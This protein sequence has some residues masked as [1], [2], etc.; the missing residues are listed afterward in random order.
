MFLRPR[1]PLFSAT[2]AGLL[3]C[4]A[5][6]PPLRADSLPTA[7]LVNF[8]SAHVS[9]L[10]VTPDGTRLL[11]VNTAAAQLMVY[12]IL[13]AGLA[14]SRVIPVGLDPVTVRARTDTEAWVVNHVSDTVT[15]LNPRTGLVTATLKTDNE[16]A[17]V[18]FAGNPQRAFVTCMQP[19]TVLVFDA[20]NPAAAPARIPLLVEEPR[21]LAVSAD[22]SRVYAA[23]YRTGNGT[24]V[25]NGRSGPITTG[26]GTGS[27][28]IIS[29]PEGPYSG[30]NP[31]PNRGAAFFPAITAPGTPPKSSLIAR[32]TADGRWLDDN[33]G[34]WSLFISGAMAP[35]TR[36]VA[37][38]DLPDR[39]VAV[40]QTATLAVT[41]QTRLMN[42]LM[43]MAVHPLTGEVTVAG[44]DA[45]NE[46][47]FEPNLNG[48]FLRVNLARFTPGGAAVIRDL[49]PH[50]DYTAARLL[51]PEQRARSLGDPRGLA[52]LADGSAAF[53]TGMGSANVAVTAGNGERLATIP[54][55]AG[56]TGIV[57]PPGN[58]RRAY[59]LNRFDASLSVLDTAA[60]AELLRLP[61]TDPTPP[62]IREGRRLL[63]DTHRTSG[64]GHISCAS[65]HVDGRT[66]HL[67]WD[68]GNP[69]GATETTGEGKTVHP[70]KG[71][72]L[73]QT[74]QDITRHPRLHWRGDR[75]SIESFHPA[76]LGL[77]SAGDGLTADEMAKL[78]AFLDTIHF[79]PNPYRN[80]NNTLPAALKLPDG[81]TANASA[82]RTLLNSDC[83][84]CHTRSKTRSELTD[85]EVGQAFIPGQFAGF[86][87]R[88][89]YDEKNT[90]TSTGGFGYF[91]DGADP[92]YVATRGL[93]LTAAILTFEGPGFGLTGAMARRDAHPAAGKQVTVTA[94]NAAAARA[95]AGALYNILI[96]SAQLGMTATGFLD[97]APR[98]YSGTS[99][100][101]VSDSGETRTISWI[102]DR[103]VAGQTFT[104][105][106]VPRGTEKRLAT[107]RNLNGV[108]DLNE[109][110]TASWVNWATLRGVTD[111]VAGNSDGDLFPNL[112]EYALSGDLGL[113]SA[114]AAP[115]LSLSGGVPA[116]SLT[117]PR[118]VTDI[119]YT[120]EQSATLRPDSWTALTG[121]PVVSV[122]ADNTETVSW[123]DVFTRAGF[124]ARG[125]LRVKVTLP[126]GAE[127]VTPPT[128]FY[129][130]ALPRGNS[131]WTAGL[132]GRAVWAG[133]VVS[134]AAAADGAGRKA[135]TLSAAA[136]P[137]GALVRHYAELLPPASSAGA[138]LDISANNGDQITVVD[139]LGACVP[140][141]RLVIR[142]HAT[143][144]TLFPGGAGLAPLSDSV[145]VFASNGGKKLHFWNPAPAP[146][147]WIDALGS[148]ATG[149]VVPPGAGVMMQTSAARALVIGADGGVAW[150]KA[151][152]LRVP[153]TPAV[154]NWAGPLTPLGGTLPLSALGFQ[155]ALRPL[156]DSVSV[157][158]P[159][160]TLKRSGTYLWNGTG[161]I[162]GS[163]T[164]AGGLP[165][166][167]GGAQVINTGVPAV[168]VLPNLLP[169]S[170]Q[171]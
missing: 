149:T 115:G 165:V 160:G 6:P 131:A 99:A 102:L 48:V 82:G 167:A 12:E 85:N 50:L 21:A 86:Y 29:R 137:Q 135:L 13:P 156:N 71:P 98:A 166:T 30:V 1:F 158:P 77:Q 146:G 78:R 153:L 117:R 20:A 22:G 129:R 100:N 121:S 75:A 27:E 142:P 144:G 19:N 63:Y 33:G 116:F 112:L 132:T 34:D 66:D 143:L 7:G 35:L 36:R 152:P 24:V 96:G 18:V 119:T 79:P 68:L 51:P 157:Y 90:A 87:D 91:H 57:I 139:P 151:G 162:S 55:G 105:T 124:T 23:G 97:G 17:D 171:P 93:D 92:I 43:A 42:V 140:G 65:C 107:D 106:L 127:A 72:M 62:A 133:S 126:G 138:T 163:G 25:L 9:P 109:P 134:A 111:G 155:S 56:P 44:T 45:T 61:F 154:N 159:D 169:Y 76:F 40:I 39:D 114:P 161:F 170:D 2:F 58:T 101:F 136:F 150:P 8:E 49:N 52:W 80:A 32:K 64:L 5:A 60:R 41:Y 104:F 113:G 164:A 47:R 118:G 16:P 14:P 70:M 125:F 4:V 10:A 110:A 147:R 28:N 11:A 95:E 37:G 148:D 69:A 123:T 141:T 54:V 3:A 94:A 46:V 122:N 67:A 73:T 168:L 128:G 15:I 145:T 130:I 120:A 108:P 81:S 88:A 26:S 53:V 31:P 59:V 83:L 74:L 38:W 89:G 84:P 103:A